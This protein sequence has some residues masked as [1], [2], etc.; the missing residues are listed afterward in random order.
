LY[1]QQPYFVSGNRRGLSKGRHPSGNKDH[2][3]SAE[4]LKRLA[5]NDKV[6]V[7]NRI[8]GAAVDCNLF[9]GSM[10]NIQRSIFNQYPV[11]LSEAKHL[12]LEILRFAQNDSF[13]YWRLDIES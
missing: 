2:F 4:S 5:R 7:M 8:K 12:C 11:M 9:Q 1:H 6:S 3:F 10:V 13:E